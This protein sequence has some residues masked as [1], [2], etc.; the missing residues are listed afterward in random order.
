MRKLSL[1]LTGSPA[2]LFYEGSQKVRRNAE[3]ESQRPDQ[4]HLEN[5]ELCSTSF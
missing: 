2:P 1:I 3:K 5:D 4:Y